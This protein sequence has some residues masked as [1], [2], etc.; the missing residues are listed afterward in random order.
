MVPVRQDDA[1]IEPQ[2]DPK[3]SF[4][5]THLGKEGAEVFA[6]QVTTE[7]ARV[8]PELRRSLIK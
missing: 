1:S 5:Y 3:L 4:D 2:G 6:A 7:L 8:V